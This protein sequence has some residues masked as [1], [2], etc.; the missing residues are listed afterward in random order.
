VGQAQTPTMGKAQTPSIQGGAI[1]D[2]SAGLAKDIGKMFG[3]VVETH[4]E[5]SEYAGKRVGTDN[6]VE[7][8]AEMDRIDAFYADKENPHSSDLA[9]R[10]REEQG[11]YEKYMQKGVFQNNPLANQS[12]KD[13]Y[14]SPA[15]NR[16]LKQKTANNANRVKLFRGE[17]VRAV[18]LEIDISNGN[19]SKANVDTWM[20]RVR[21]V[22]V[23]PQTVWG[24][25][26]NGL[27][28]AFTNKF[29]D[30]LSSVALT[31]Y[32]ENGILTQNGLDRLFNDT[33]G[34]FATRSNGEFSKEV[35]SMTDE[36]YDAIKESFNGW[37]NSTLGPA[38]KKS[39]DIS[40]VKSVNTLTVKNSVS[41][42]EQNDKELDKQRLE[43][44]SACA[45]DGEGSNACSKLPILRDAKAKIDILK[46]QK[47]RLNERVQQYVDSDTNDLSSLLNKIEVATTV[48]SYSGLD[49]V[50]KFGEVT[51]KEVQEYAHTFLNGKLN[52]ILLSKDINI[53]SA[54]ATASKIASLQSGGITGS[55]TTAGNNSMKQTSSLSSIQNATTAGQILNNL[56]FA[57]SYKEGTGNVGYSGLSKQTLA[58]ATQYYDELLQRQKSDPKQYTDS[59]IL[60]QM[61][62][63]VGASINAQSKF[64]YERTIK[65]LDGIGLSYDDDADEIISGEFFGYKVG[66]TRMTEGSVS[67][68]LDDISKDGISYADEEAVKNGAK[69]R[70]LVID[71]SYIPIWST[72]QAIAKPSKGKITDSE[73]RDNLMD[74][75]KYKL[76]AN[77]IMLN[78]DFTDIVDADDIQFRQYP[79][80]RLGLQTIVEIIDGG[81]VVSRAIIDDD[82]WIKGIT[83]EQKAESDKRSYMKRTKGIF[84]GAH[85]ETFEDVRATKKSEFNLSIEGL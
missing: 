10:T 56:Q 9:S 84:S 17:E 58:T 64:A 6:L 46:Q 71:K 72:S 35:V 43:M 38:R 66:E 13:T 82:E 53:D 22:G 73:W 74:V 50:T 75:A 36:S 8:N 18:E 42:I 69:S 34:E 33:K 77:A 37:I 4:Q 16:L 2:R 7:Y 32:L 55:A 25:V 1:I 29:K 62:V 80:Q 26:A 83:Q 59:H 11:L 61:R 78:I 57:V 49:D 20:N 63:L 39:V 15:A 79:D 21:A 31:P 24:D 19:F 30:G 52:A 47:Y 81:K 44:A 23:N 27:N 48:K 14:A 85:E 45:I 51:V 3:N 67:I 68:V 65:A 54:M 5:A 60:G 70:M 12:F 41:S 40:I 76:Q 28:S